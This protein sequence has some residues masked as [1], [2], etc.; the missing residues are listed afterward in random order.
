MEAVQPA[1]SSNFSL[2]GTTTIGVALTINLQPMAYIQVSPRQSKV[3]TSFGGH[4]MC[5]RHF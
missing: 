3:P 1:S 2:C 4:F 5:I